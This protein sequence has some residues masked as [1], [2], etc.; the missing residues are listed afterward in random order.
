[1]HLII[2][3]GKTKE[4]ALEAI[5]KLSSL[6]K[7]KKHWQKVHPTNSTLTDVLGKDTMALLDDAYEVRCALVH[8][9]SDPGVKRARR[10]SKRLLKHL[11]TMRAKFKADCGYSGW[12]RLGK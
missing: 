7:L 10:L 5:Q 6:N 9:E 1:M 8:G 3:Q 2:K 12:S 4:Q 11:D